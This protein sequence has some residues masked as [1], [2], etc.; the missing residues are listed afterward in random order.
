MF[1]SEELEF[2][3]KE[4]N[5]EDLQCLTSIVMS[6]RDLDKGNS[7]ES[8]IRILWRLQSDSDKWDKPL[9]EFARK[10]K[11]VFKKVDDFDYIITYYERKE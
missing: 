6:K 9:K 3:N 11:P 2:L 8:F 1:T 4:L 7:E 5:R 10:F